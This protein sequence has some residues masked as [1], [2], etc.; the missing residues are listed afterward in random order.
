MSE[1][2][3]QELITMK[4]LFADKLRTAHL[5]TITV[6]QTDPGRWGY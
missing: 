3:E 2:T 1:Q 4:N 6:T 5:H